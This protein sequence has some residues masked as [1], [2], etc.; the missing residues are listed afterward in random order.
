M[1][2]SIM[3]IAQYGLYRR[4]YERERLAEMNPLYTRYC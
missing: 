4:L 1:I 2:N 3:T